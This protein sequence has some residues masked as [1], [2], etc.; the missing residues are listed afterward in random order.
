MTVHQASGLT[1]G[2]RSGP[3]A[4]SRQPRTAKSDSLAPRGAVLGLVSGKGGVGKSALAVNVAVAAARS[5]ARVLLI[6]ADAGLANDELLLG[7]VPR[8]NL[9][10]WSLGGR[11]LEEVLC[12]G[13]FGLSLL[14]GGESEVARH[15]LGRAVGGESASELGRF[16]AGHTLTIVDLGAGIDRSLLAIAGRCAPLWLV[17]TPEPTSL[18]DAYATLKCV[19]DAEPAQRVELIVNRAAQSQSGERTHLA[20]NRLAR[21]FLGNSLPLRGVVPEDAAL[22]RSVSR[23]S[24]LVLD[25]GSSIAGRRFELL[26]ESVLE[27]IEA[28][29]DLQHSHAKRG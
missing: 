24:P 1:L 28:A 18:A 16:I 12:G 3:T 4:T 23:Q 20:L 15:A 11:G 27:E 22:I 8:F 9:D 25:S 17:A 7:L 26:A 14:V 2:S 10:D 13:P 29:I 21:R 6:D 19:W 5:G